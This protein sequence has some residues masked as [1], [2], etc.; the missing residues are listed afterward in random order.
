[1]LEASN[2]S[3]GKLFLTSDKLLEVGNYFSFREA[4][5]T[6]SYCPRGKEQEFNDSGAWARKGRVDIRVGRFI[7]K[8][9][10]SGDNPLP[11]S[12]IESFVNKFKALEEEV[13]WK[14]AETEEDID[15]VYDCA[16]VNSCMKGESVGDFYASVGARVLY[17]T[18]KD[19]WIIGRALLWD[20][21][22]TTTEPIKLMDRI[23]GSDSTIALF[24]FWAEDNGYHNLTSNC[25]GCSQARLLENTVTI[26]TVTVKFP[27][28]VFYPYMDTFSHANSDHLTVTPYQ[29]Y[30]LL[31][32]DGRCYEESDDEDDDHYG[33]TWSD[34]E[35]RWIDDDDVIS[36]GNNYH[37]YD[38]CTELTNGR[39]VLS[40]DAVEIE[41]DGQEVI[42]HRDEVPEKEPA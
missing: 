22:N 2:S 26:T 23:Y 33:E 37:H 14:I 38:N 30:Y 1:M 11:D 39:C 24:K 27:K 40:E 15:N 16:D 19:K 21:V 7:K 25:S 31:N 8:V 29:E 36:I 28:N 13:A 17:A 18:N 20:K 32:T 35:E 5:G 10:G 4:A 9:F 6:I 42:V 41:I 12:D 34:Y 3:V